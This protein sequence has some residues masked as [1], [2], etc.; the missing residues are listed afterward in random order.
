[1]GTALVAAAIASFLALIVYRYLRYNGTK[2]E[3]LSGGTY[4]EGKGDRQ[5]G[6]F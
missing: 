3:T 6:G 2:K 5:M 4:F 1:M